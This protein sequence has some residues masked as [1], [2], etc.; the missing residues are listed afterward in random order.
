[1]EELQEALRGNVSPTHLAPLAPRSRMTHGSDIS[2]DSLDGRRTRQLPDE[3]DEPSLASMSLGDDSVFVSNASSFCS[4]DVKPPVM[5]FHL[6]AR[7]PVSAYL[8]DTA[9]KSSRD[10]MQ[11]Y[12]K[13][14]PVS[15]PS[16]IDALAS[17]EQSN[18]SVESD[19]K[20]AVQSHGTHL[21]QRQEKAEEIVVYISDDTKQDSP[22]HLPFYLLSPIRESSE[23]ST[24][25][26]GCSRK[27]QKPET[28]L[29]LLSAS[30][31]ALGTM[32][33]SMATET[34]TKYQ[35]FPR[36]KI[37]VLSPVRNNACYD[38]PEDP[39][40]YPLEPRE[41]DLE[42]FQQ[43]H[44]ADSQEE[45]QEFLLLESQCMTT[46]NRR[47]LAAAFHVTDDDDSGKLGE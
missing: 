16:V 11:D 36:S 35:T 46:D 23:H 8:T 40:M 22:A 44:N 37:P 3:P 31:E 39:S 14:H 43:L 25:S 15:I 5:S 9:N 2:D 38:V 6:S 10:V 7:Q 34:K 1:M 13:A 33:S 27:S 26:S 30:C 42:S 21:R 32:D 19:F 4:V 41:L 45:L 20:A 47:G 28:T 29:R 17:N 24:A 12:I 18:Q